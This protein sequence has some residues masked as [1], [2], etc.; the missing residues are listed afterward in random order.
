MASKILVVGGCGYIGGFLTDL[1]TNQAYD[2]TVYDSL[3][4][5]TR[6]LKNVNFIRGDIRDTEKLEKIIHDYDTVVWLAALV[7]DGACAVDLELTKR[8]NFDAVKWLVDNFKGKIV[9]TS[10]CSVYGAN[11][12]LIDETATP[13]R[14]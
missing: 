4:Y 13:N 6:Y 9:F 14:Y 12:D 8:I 5:E 11:N 7:G 10:T 3:L 1:L 2:V